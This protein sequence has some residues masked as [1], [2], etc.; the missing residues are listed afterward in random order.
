M[1]RITAY[2]TSGVA[3]HFP[4]EP[5]AHTRDWMDSAPA[6]FANRCLPLKMANQSGWVIK[7]ANSFSARRTFS[8]EPGRSVEFEYENGTPPNV[9]SA[10]QDLFGL[11]IFTFHLPY[12]FRTEIG[13]A[14]IARGAPN[15]AVSNAHPLEGI[16]ET[17]WTPATFTMNW[18]ILESGATCTFMQGDPLCF[19][20]PTNLAMLE[21]MEPHLD[22]IE[23]DP[24][25]NCAYREWKMSRLA[26]NMDPA[27]R[28]AG[29]QKDYYRGP[30]CQ[31]GGSA[32]PLEHRTRINLRDFQT[33]A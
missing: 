24:G 22:A 17:D 28:A 15:F 5:A 11:G 8:D 12:L 27:Q 19:V 18:R 9:A 33:D 13:Y 7:T 31:N 21:D 30:H 2:K 14:L 1:A 32:P 26:F 6:Q 25:L 10:I 20:Q 3:R 16:I 29:W 23:S 4:I